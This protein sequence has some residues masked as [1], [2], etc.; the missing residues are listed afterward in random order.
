MPQNSLHVHDFALL[1][2]QSLKPREPQ[3]APLRNLNALACISIE[4]Q[5]LREH[6]FDFLLQKKPQR[7]KVSDRARNRER[8]LFVQA[9]LPNFLHGLE[10]VGSVSRIDL[11]DQVTPATLR[12]E[13][14]FQSASVALLQFDQPRADVVQTAQLPRYWG[15]ETQVGLRF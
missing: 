4:K 3:G 7:R 9:G 12:S 1:R 11:S 6:A 5:A 8:R 2:R 10:H 13:S 14:N 15:K